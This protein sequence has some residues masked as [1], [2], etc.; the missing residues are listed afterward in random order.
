MTH[1][2]QFTLIISLLMLSNCASAPWKSYPMSQSP[3]FSCVTGS[4]AGY[5]VYVWKC[6]DGK[7]VVIS[8]K[9]AGLYGCHS[10][11]KE[12]VAC[13]AKT[14]REELHFMR[15]PSYPNCQNKPILWQTE[16]KN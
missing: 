16:S 9:C 12:V 14:K 1:I 6:L 15:E 2:K 4:E 8:Q 13:G 5:D 10:T 3:D 11:K 7:R